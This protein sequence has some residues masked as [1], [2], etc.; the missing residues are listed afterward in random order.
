MNIHRSPDCL[1]KTVAA[2]VDGR[3]HKKWLPSCAAAFWIPRAR[4]GEDIG[5][6][7]GLAMMSCNA[8]SEVAGRVGNQTC[9]GDLHMAPGL[10]LLRDLIIDQHFA[11]RGRIGRLL[12]AVAQ[13][14]RVLGVGIDEDTAI[15]VNGSQFRVQ[16]TGAVYIVD[17]AGVTYSNVAEAKPDRVLSL[18]DVRLHV[19]IA[20]R[21][22]T[23]LSD[24]PPAGPMAHSQDSHV[25][26]RS[27]SVRCR[28][29]D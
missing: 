26:K 19:L 22:S 13:N 24:V 11:E 3:L 25:D 14:P 16:G 8:R 2:S 4:H 15:I 7:A 29:A 10:G 5:L 17:A 20:V 18:C 28:S 21:R 27:R 12:G 6:A 1:S 23:W 9:I